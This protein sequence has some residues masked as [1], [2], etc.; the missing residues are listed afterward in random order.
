ME[1]RN[2]YGR[3]WDTLVVG[4]GAAGC[5]AAIAAAGQGQRVLLLEKMKK[6]EKS[7]ILPARDG[8]I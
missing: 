4:A 2:E 7:Y 1:K 3:D 5:M 6:S 8:A